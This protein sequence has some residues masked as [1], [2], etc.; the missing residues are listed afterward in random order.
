MII[1]SCFF[2]DLYFVLFYDII[3]KNQFEL[4][5]ICIFFKYFTHLL[6]AICL[7]TKLI[8]FLADF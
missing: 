5:V 2:I 7:L 3:C 6:Y 4:Y 1:N 8:N